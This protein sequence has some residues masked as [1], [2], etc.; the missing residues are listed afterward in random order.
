MPESDQMLASID[1]S[2]IVNVWDVRTSVPLVNLEIHDGKGLAVAW[3]GLNDEK[4]RSV[5]SGGSDCCLKSFQM[6]F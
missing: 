4:K 1:Y 2:G 5:V 6:N 3:T